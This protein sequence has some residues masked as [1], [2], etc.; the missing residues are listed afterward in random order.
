MVGRH[1][2][3]S[4]EAAADDAANDSKTASDKLRGF[5]AL[6]EKANID[7]FIS[8]RKLHDLLETVFNQN[9]LVA[10]YHIEK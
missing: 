2:L 10:L 3:N 9:W 5:M 4:V 1:L 8:H 7:R 6:I